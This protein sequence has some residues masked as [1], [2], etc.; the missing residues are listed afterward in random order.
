[1]S[2]NE[3]KLIALFDSHTTDL[4]NV[5]PGA[6]D[7]FVCPICRNRFTRQNI[8]DKRLTD[9]HVWPDYMR[10]KRGNRNAKTQRVL[11][12]QPCNSNVGSHGDKHMQLMQEVRDGLD[13]GN[14]HGERLIRL[15]ESSNNVT[16]KLRTDVSIESDKV[17]NISGQIDENGKWLRN[18]PKMQEKFELLAKQEEKVAIEIHSPKQYIAPN[19]TIAGWI[20][21]AYLFA[22]YRLGYRYIL[23]DTLAPVRKYIIRSSIKSNA[24]KLV[25]PASPVISFQEYKKLYFPDPELHLIIPIDGKSHVH[26]QIS[27]LKYQVRLPFFFVPDLLSALIYGSVPDLKERLPQLREED[28]FLYVPI[29]TDKFNS[30][31]NVFDYILGK[32]LNG[33]LS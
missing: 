22:F 13:S 16:I 12:C 2:S 30:L 18:D 15:V 28:T 27:F 31:E 8:L 17:I 6:G 14:L 9:G 24:E 23:N 26:L 3:R 5:Y 1:M 7:I 10:A 25:L 20:T 33:F 21:S 11:L 29:I 32:P 19:L 4:N